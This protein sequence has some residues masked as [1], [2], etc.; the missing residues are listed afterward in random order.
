MDRAVAHELALRCHNALEPLHAFVYFS[1]EVEQTFVDAGLEADRMTYFAGR[2]APLGPVGAGVV[3]ATFHNFNPRLVARH[4]PRAWELVDPSDIVTLRFQAA[5]SG[6]RRLLGEA[7]EAPEL[8]ELAALVREAA[9]LCPPE[10]RPL[11]AAHA[12]LPWPDGPVA[13]VWHGATLLREFRGD[14]HVAALVA[15]GVS[16]LEALVTHTATGKGFRADVARR[17]RGWSE[18]EWAAAEDALRDQGV[19]DDTGTLTDRGRARRDALEERTN[20][21]AST[22]YRLL[23]E[24]KVRRIVELAK[25]LSRTVLKAGAIPRDLFANR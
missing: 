9:E 15:E 25:P 24:D 13:A 12:D 2:A 7:A 4:I 6:L 1:P 19:L 20:D 3:T 23:G 10:G 17:L 5:E 14:G 8:I 21:A 16:G 11:F 18:Q 22:P